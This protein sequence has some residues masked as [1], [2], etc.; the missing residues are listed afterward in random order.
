M[1]AT[2]RKWT[3]EEREIV[4]RVYPSQG[5][6]GVQR[7]LPHRKKVAITGFARRNAVMVTRAPKQ[8]TVVRRPD[9]VVVAPPTP[10]LADFGLHMFKN[11]SLPENRVVVRKDGRVIAVAQV[12]CLAI[13]AGALVV[14]D[15]VVMHPSA[16]PAFRAWMRRDSDARAER[17]RRLP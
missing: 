9:S 13:I 1:R 10:K 5:Y 7:L 8:E 2:D 12:E 16:A 14:A 6:L 15:D 4:F 17:A 11:E 3:D